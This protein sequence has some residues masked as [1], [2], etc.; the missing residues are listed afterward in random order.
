M[1]NV[2]T[3]PVHTGEFLLGG[4]DEGS[5]SFE[6]VIIL[7]GQN[8]PA[9]KILGKV[10]A[11][12]KCKAYAADAT[13]GSETAVGILYAATDATAADQRATMVARLRE[14]DRALLTGLDAAAEADLKALNIIVRG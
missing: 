2:L 8:L 5:L 6:S 9:G 4:C 3:E 11:S 10:T 7:M 13:D 12:G 14:V 1:A